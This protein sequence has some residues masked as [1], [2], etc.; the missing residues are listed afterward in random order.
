MENVDALVGGLVE[1]PVAGSQLGALF[2]A[3][4]CKQLHVL[5][6]SDPWY[7]ENKNMFDAT[8]MFRRSRGCSKRVG[9][10]GAVQGSWSSWSLLNL[11]FLAFPK[12]VKVCAVS[13]W[14]SC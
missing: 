10:H 6:D 11:I 8:G 3:I 12:T 7:F 14:P 4:F 1:E 13:P 2:S 9:K 5:R